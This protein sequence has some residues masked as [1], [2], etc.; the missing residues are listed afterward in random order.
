MRDGKNA[1]G[2]PKDWDSIEIS[3]KQGSIIVEASDWTALH[4]FVEIAD[5]ESDKMFIP[6]VAIS[7]GERGSS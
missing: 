6:R 5:P 1:F 4:D 3:G 7:S 2:H